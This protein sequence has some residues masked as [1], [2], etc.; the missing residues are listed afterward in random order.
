MSITTIQKVIKVGD[1]K[2]ATFPAKELKRL[3]IELGDEVKLTIEPIKPRT[4]DNLM[5]EYQAFKNQYGQTLKN[6]RDR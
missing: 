4:Q 6:L 1:S 3:G 2:G 5:D